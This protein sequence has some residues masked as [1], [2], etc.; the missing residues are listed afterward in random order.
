M[1]TCCVWLYDLWHTVDVIM[2]VALPLQCVRF[3]SH[4]TVF[5]QLREDRTKIA[6]IG[7]GC[8]LATE[9][10][11]E[12]SHFWNIPQVCK[13]VRELMHGKLCKSGCYIGEWLNTASSKVQ[14]Y[15]GIIKLS[16]EQKFIMRAFF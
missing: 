5:S 7:S 6:A 4:R 13:V 10:A 3:R 8:S 1:I 9:P 16:R 12:I 11:A 15:S 14:N 2:A